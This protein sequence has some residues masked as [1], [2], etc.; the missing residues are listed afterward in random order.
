MVSRI[1]SCPEQGVEEAPSIR[2]LHRHPEHFGFV[3]SALPITASTLHSSVSPVVRHPPKCAGP[4]YLR[5]AVAHPARS[6][7]VGTL[8]TLSFKHGH[9]LGSR[10]CAISVA[11]PTR[12][13][14]SLLTFGGPPPSSPPPQKPWRPGFP[15]K[16]WVRVRGRRGPYEGPID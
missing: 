12:G 1:N 2:K 9:L 14:A 13:T 11:D 16:P 15:P 8:L 5:G 7:R 4:G 3:A 6:E 10:K